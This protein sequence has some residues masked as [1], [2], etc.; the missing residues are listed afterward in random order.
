MIEE[1]IEAVVLAEAR[2]DKE[3]VN[4]RDTELA[5]I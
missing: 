1:E 3:P 5:V 2:D 4:V